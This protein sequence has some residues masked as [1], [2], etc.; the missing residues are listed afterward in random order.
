MNKNPDNAKQLL[1][2]QVG[3][4]LDA[5][6]PPKSRDLGRAYLQSYFRRVP[7]AE[8]A[9]L[10]AEVLAAM[11]ESQLRFM[12]T[13]APGESLLRVY[14][15]T[16]AK[17]GWDSK[18]TIVEMVNDDKPFLVD[19]ATLA[20][21][22]MGLDIRLIVHP[23]I[24]VRRGKTGKLLGIS[25]RDEM[26]GSAESVMQIQVN[27]QGSTETLR[28]IREVLDDTL[29]DVGLAVR[30]WHTMVD[31]ARQTGLLMAEWAPKTNSEVM[32]ESQEFMSW[33][34]DNHFIFLGVRDYEVVKSGKNYAQRIIPGSGLGILEEGP[35]NVTT[36]PLSDLAEQARTRSVDTPLIITKTNSRSTV[37][38]VG[39]M[40]YIGVLRY[41]P[42]GN[43]IGERRFLGLFTSSAYGLSV[44]E[45]PLVRG[46]VNQVVEHLGLTHGSHAYKTLMHILETLPRDE[47]FQASARELEEIAEGVL[48]LQERRR[49]RLFIRREQYG[50]FYSCLVYIPRERFNTENREKIQTILKRALGGKK[51]DYVV[52][53]SESALARLHV[54][55]R[56]QPGASPQP[57]V[58]LLEQKIVDA[59]HSWSD[60]LTT[61]LVQQQGEEKGL[62]LADRFCPAFPEAYK[63]DVSPW[64]AAFDVDN[65]AA[66][67]RGEDL[68]MSLYRPRKVRGG[69]IRFKLFRKHQPIPLSQVLPMLENL[70]LG[71]I[72]ERPYELEFADEQRIW[73]QDFDMAPVVTRE[74]NLETI[75]SLFQEAFRKAMSGEI[76][77]DKFNQLVIA[78]ELNWRQVKVLRAYCKYLLQIGTP[79]SQ[80]YMAETLAKFPLVSRIL[81]EL[82]EAMFEPDR[83]TESVH[84]RQQAVRTLKRTMETLLTEPF[85]GDELLA[86]YLEDVYK[87]RQKSD[88][89]VQ[90]QSLRVA[91][92][93]ALTSVS[94]LD[95][96]RILYLFY[97]IIKATLRTSFFRRDE[98]GEIGD[99]ISFKI[100]SGKVTDLPLPKPFREIWVY[101]P[102]FEGIH[103]RGGMIARGGLRWSD[104]REDF[105][106]EVLGLMKAQNV[107]N[108]M[109]V[110]VGAKGGFV[111]KRPPTQG[112]REAIQQ[113]GVHCYKRFINALLDITDNLSEDKVMYPE[114]VVRRDGDDPYLVVAADKGTATFSDIANGISLQRG[115]WL[116]DAFASGGSVGYDHK[117]MGITAKGAWEGVKRHFR[118]LGMDIQKQPFTVV[119][120]GDMS[121]DVFGN[122]MLLS[123]KICLRAAFNHLHIFLDPN[124]DPVTSFTERLRLFRKPRSG[125]D[126]YNPLKISAGGGVYSRLDKTIPLSKEVRDWLGVSETQL[127]PH[128]LIRLLLKAPVD[129]LWNGGIGTYVKSSKES[130]AD[131]GDMANNPLRVNG[132]ELQCR[133][134]GEG[135]NLGCTQRGRIEFAMAGGRINTDFIDNSA[136]VDTSDHEVNIKILLAQA[137]RSGKLKE[138]DRPA[139]LASM[140]DEVAALVVRSNY[141]Q[142]QAISMM[143]TLKGPRMGSKQHFVAKMEEQ[144]VLNRQLEFLPDDD[145]LTERRNRGEGLTRP[146]LSVLLSYSKI[147]VYQQLLTSDLHEDPYLSRELVRYFPVPLQKRFATV[148]EEHRLRREIIA[149]QVTNSMVNRMG[150]SFCL[151]MQEDTDA[152]PA[153]VAKAFTIAREIFAAR[154]FWAEVESLDNRVPAELQTQA[155]LVMWNVL[156]QSTRWVLIRKGGRLDVNGMIE[157]WSPGLKAMEKTILAT[158]APGER[159]A[160]EQEKQARVE[161]GIPEALAHRIA[162]L[163]FLLPALDVVETAAQRK[164]AVQD[165]ALVY[166]QLGEL[167]QLKWL[168]EQL[169]AL[170]VKGQ[171]HAHARAI[172]RD[173]LFSR[174]NHLVECILRDS[175]R[176][177][178][179]VSHWIGKHESRV[180]PV[181]HFMNEMKELPEMDYA[182]LSVAVRSLG[183][184]LESGHHA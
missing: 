60:E 169:E 30:D 127:A 83:E 120:I 4:A 10:N 144:G 98:K 147:V 23:V 167:L 140:T 14:N 69:M 125:W 109:I 166:F 16:V 47:L 33:L 149:T 79:F 136:G 182:T 35:G 28:K 17:D 106:T 103:L 174:H 13:R 105:R 39:Y 42:R 156:R 52:N 112:G 152:S 67:D 65:A 56:P 93:R 70:G 159:E 164:L 179:P 18:H 63:E 49:V 100:E 116:A 148:M 19:S 101:S 64:V 24:R 155:L 85:S 113:E 102:R 31:T 40:D 117:A 160:M 176:N 78:A 94:S 26:D 2:E 121:G 173:E 163:P 95:E 88:R 131:V 77:S 96:D 73:I 151:R 170:P 8:M 66:V 44:M 55:I 72:S 32:A 183:Q 80:S 175:G 53:V 74:L 168:R 6:L 129:L 41:D 15:P 114:N 132:N 3:A 119:G 12:A 45:T 1:L 157:R 27:R 153:A 61:I 108:T 82:F 154:D 177:K 178:D 5:R 165:V 76:D 115:F 99:Y 123:K 75:R 138:K 130:N 7:L 184:M 150:V 146:E 171:W 122:G 128:E 111:L 86:E 134:V 161:A 21:A 141:L 181:I 59:V 118:E 145:Q 158:L 139:L 104:R 84:R 22:E 51:L 133:V 62:K 50:R 97:D 37:H 142:T 34:I 162:L 81:T 43:I 38:R 48:N 54:I 107:K 124:P 36:R 172:L 92:Q 71:I 57:D 11:L 68:R 135:G 180:R 58:A 87:A 90:V 137:I 126:D 20:L 143:E 46:R 25:T 9:A 89:E 110:P 91:F 29:R